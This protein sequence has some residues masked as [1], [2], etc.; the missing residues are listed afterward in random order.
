MLTSTLAV[1]YSM[2]WTLVIANVITVLV[3]L[4]TLP[5]PQIQCAAD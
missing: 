3:C 4:A 5:Y 1:T 2:V